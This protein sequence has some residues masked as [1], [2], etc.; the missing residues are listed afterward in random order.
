MLSQEGSLDEIQASYF[1]IG[2]SKIIAS[3]NIFSPNDSLV[4]AALSRGARLGWGFSH[5]VNLRFESQCY[6]FYVV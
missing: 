3:R 1:G 6:S 4:L 2:Y 5:L